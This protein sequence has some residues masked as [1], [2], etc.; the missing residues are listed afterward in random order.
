MGDVW[1]PN[2]YQAM[3]ETTSKPWKNN[4]FIQLLSCMKTTLL[5]SCVILV[6][7]I[8]RTLV[9]KIQDGRYLCVLFEETG[10]FATI[11]PNSPCSHHSMD[12]ECLFDCTIHKG[13]IWGTVLVANLA[14]NFRI[15]IACN[16]MPFH[17]W[18]QKR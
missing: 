7:K 12:F 1:K 8:Q 2:L 3:C 15:V 11:L 6:I 16:I 18:L 10:K 14:T 9:T 5:P 4:S 13:S 17:A